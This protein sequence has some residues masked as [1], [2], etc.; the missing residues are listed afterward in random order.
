MLWLLFA[1]LSNFFRSFSRIANQFLRKKHIADDS[2]FILIMM[3]FFSIIWLAFLP[4]IEI[5]VPPIPQLIAA[6]ASGFII[7]FLSIFPY[8][9]ALSREELSS[10]VPILNLST[11]FVLVI[12]VIFLGEKL[13][14]KSYA[15]FS[16][17]FL[18]GMIITVE[19]V[20]GYLR[21][22][23][24]LL[25]VLGA[26]IGSAISLTLLKFFF[27]TESYWNGFFW[28]NFGSIIATAVILFFPNSVKNL[29]KHSNMIKGKVALI[30]LIAVIF[31][32]LGDLSLL[33]AMKLGPISL[34]SVIGSTQMAFM[35]VIALLFSRFL[36]SVLKERTD[37]KTLLKK[38][39]AIAIMI[40]GVVL[41][42][43]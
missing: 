13:T 29:K 14:G 19:K 38:S 37:R 40:V 7:I 16:L 17:L 12:S 3:F 30:F 15:G 9:Y 32:L 24:T 6:L 34:V 22:N 27:L 41:L 26:A 5:T 36:P 11:L 33:Y 43:N 8:V 20:K 2:S 18:A 39:I 21:L 1:L 28:F 10:I 4:F 35:F 25:V 23:K 42:N 31:G